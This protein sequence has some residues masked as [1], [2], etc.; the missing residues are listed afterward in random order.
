MSRSDAMIAPKP[1]KNP[2]AVAPYCAGGLH[3]TKYARNSMKEI[4]PK[5]IILLIESVKL[6]TL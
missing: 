1:I 4:S 6:T 5:A 2:R 3:L